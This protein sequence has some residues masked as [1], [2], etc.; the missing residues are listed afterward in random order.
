MNQAG[1]EIGVGFQERTD[2]LRR[3]VAAPRQGN[4]RMERPQIGFETSGK[5]GFLDA[6][7]KLEQMRMARA[8]A[9]P[10]NLRPAFRGE[11][12]EADEREKE[13]FP[14]DGSE[15]F[16]KQFLSF[17]GDIA[18][19]RESQMHLA[20]L[21]PADAADARIHFREKLTDGFGKLEADEEAFGTHRI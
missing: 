10:D 5:H 4:V 14:G 16:G 1:V 3:N 9:D 17:S 18:K 20:R 11:C 8:D 6:F 13:R 2:R 12:A 19:E 15:F 21:E 7:V